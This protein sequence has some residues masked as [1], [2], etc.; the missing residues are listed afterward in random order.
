[1][2]FP[3][4]S[5]DSQQTATIEYLFSAIKK[6]SE[7]HKTCVGNMIKPSMSAL[8]IVAN[9]E[10]DPHVSLHLVGV[11]L[12]LQALACI[13]DTRPKTTRPSSEED[14]HK[15]SSVEE[16]KPE[17]KPAPVEEHKP[18]SKPARAKKCIW[19]TLIRFPLSMMNCLHD[20]FARLRPF[21]VMMHNLLILCFQN[22]CLVVLTLG[23]NGNLDSTLVAEHIVMLFVICCLQAHIEHPDRSIAH[24]VLAGVFGKMLF[25]RNF[26]PIASTEFAKAPSNTEVETLNFQVLQNESRNVFICTGFLPGDCKDIN[27]GINRKIRLAI[28]ICVRMSFFIHVCLGKKKPLE[29]SPRIS[30][31]VRKVA[32]MWSHV[33]YKK[34]C[35]FS[36][37]GKMKAL[38]VF[39]KTQNESK[40][41]AYWT[42]QH[43]KIVAKSKM[44][45]K[46]EMMD[47]DRKVSDAK[48][49]K[50]ENDILLCQNL[51]M[52]ILILDRF[53][54]RM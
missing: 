37:K 29:E 49:N 21:V 39:L 15:S 20:S 45:Q 51:Y 44:L 12:L 24:K 53:V 43:W 31:T 46:T 4:V 13:T 40:R 27:K 33:E 52:C 23:V 17:S 14:A 41:T 11:I 8:A 19:K 18:E 34:L 35:E 54:K 26:C 50:L 22:M 5:E 10:P 42:F 3:V 38:R 48:L 36:S 7:E 28:D 9:F 47:L 25:P 30:V 16:H 32:S 6:T 2:H 1:L